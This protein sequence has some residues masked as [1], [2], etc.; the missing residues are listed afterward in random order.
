MLTLHDGLPRFPGTEFP[1]L[2]RMIARAR[3]TLSGIAEKVGGQ[4]LFTIASVVA[5][6]RAA[7][8]GYDTATIAVVTLMVL[9]ATAWC[10]RGAVQ[11]IRA[12][13]EALP[14]HLFH[15]GNTEAV[16]LAI[17]ADFRGRA[18]TRSPLQ[19]GGDWL[20]YARG[21]EAT[22]VRLEDV[23][24]AYGA[25]GA[26][27]LVG[28]D[29]PTSDIVL[30]E[31]RMILLDRRGH[32]QE[33]RMTLADVS[34]GLAEIKRAAPWLVV[35]YSDAMRETWNADRA[36]LLAMVE[37]WRVNGD[38]SS[39]IQVPNELAPS[40]QVRSPQAHMPQIW[41]ALAAA[42]LAGLVIFYLT[43]DT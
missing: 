33:L 1:F 11:V 23:I 15:Q 34:V 41:L 28:T 18:P 16:A 8:S 14:R 20:L 27:S 37:S 6:S 21:L 7:R 38:N 35:G 29:Q 42:V 19:I 3:P 9:A 43:R 32:K 39:P 26:E 24:W 2:A 4:L 30:S 31:P 17:E 5:L 13:R 36:E 12:S 40:T 25:A 22:A 10:L